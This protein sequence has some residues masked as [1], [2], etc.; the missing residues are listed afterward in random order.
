VKN[1][2]LVLV[3]LSLAGCSRNIQN[4]EAV[5]QAVVEYLDAKAAQTGLKMDS[6]DVDVTAL[7]F[8]QQQARA[9]VNFRL[10]QGGG[11]MQMT[12]VLDQKG[13]KWVVR[14][15]Q[16][17]TANPHGTVPL[18]PGGDTGAAPALPPNHPSV[19][20]GTAPPSGVE[21]PPGHPPTG[22]KQ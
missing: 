11:G 1:I 6:M 7:T 16:V 19:S 2:G 5:R 12:Y 14:G 10:K 4:K 22:S 21:L 15:T 20:G 13:G 3:L 18:P 8:E 9:T 17:S